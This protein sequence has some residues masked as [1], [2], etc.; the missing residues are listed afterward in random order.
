MSEDPACLQASIHITVERTN[1]DPTVY[2]VRIGYWGYVELV[3]GRGRNFI[4]MFNCC[5]STHVWP[6]SS[7]RPCLGCR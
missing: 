7:L 5:D 6:M 4:R 3:L 2:T 1:G